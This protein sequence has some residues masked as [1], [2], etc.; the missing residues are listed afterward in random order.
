LL[1]RTKKNYFNGNIDNPALLLNGFDFND[2][3][4]MYFY[5]HLK[6]KIWY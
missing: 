6:G 1:Y 4:L 3:V 5:N 2:I